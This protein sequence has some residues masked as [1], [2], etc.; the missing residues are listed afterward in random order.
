YGS[1]HVDYLRY[2]L[3]RAEEIFQESAD[4]TIVTDVRDVMEDLA[5]D[6]GASLF[7]IPITQLG[8]GLA[9]LAPSKEATRNREVELPSS[10]GVPI[11]PDASKL[12]WLEEE[13]DLVGMNT[14]ELAPEGREIGK[15]FLSG[16]V[17]AWCDLAHHIDVER[18]KT[19]ILRRILDTEL[20]RR[21]AV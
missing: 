16:A 13:I 8:H 17:I 4:Y 3:E 19:G 10:S 2:I 14:S 9:R 1:E 5:R 15:D 21:H 12:R 20:K 18:T 7:A 6:L 11:T